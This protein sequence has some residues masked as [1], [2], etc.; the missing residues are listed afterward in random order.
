MREIKEQHGVK[1]LLLNCHLDMVEWL[2]CLNDPQ[3]DA[4]QSFGS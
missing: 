4:N 1:S 2:A 3:G